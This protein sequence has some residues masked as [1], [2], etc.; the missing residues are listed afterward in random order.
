MGRAKYKYCFL[1]HHSYKTSEEFAVKLLR[2]RHQSEKYKMDMLMD[3]FFKLNNLT[4]EKLY[5]IESIV[6]R[7]FPKFHKSKK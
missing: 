1:R 5:L 7:T 4:E 3:Y 2:G 6:N